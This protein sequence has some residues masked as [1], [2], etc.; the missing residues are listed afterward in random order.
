MSTRSAGPVGDLNASMTPW[1]LRSHTRVNGTRIVPRM[2]AHLECRFSGE[3]D[4]HLQQTS[5]HGGRNHRLHDAHPHAPCE[6]ASIFDY[7]TYEPG[8]RAGSMLTPATLHDCDV[9]AGTCKPQ[10]VCAARRCLGRRS[11]RRAQT[12]EAGVLA[13][14]ARAMALLPPSGSAGPE[15]CALWLGGRWWTCS[16]AANTVSATTAIDSLPR[17]KGRGFLLQDDGG[18]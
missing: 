15:A 5:K 3:D 18:R 13:D 7:L 4:E 16:I 6:V 2:C 1:H 12:F 10:S 14:T 17:P 11:A 9:V 8:V